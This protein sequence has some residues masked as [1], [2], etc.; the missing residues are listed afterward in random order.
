MCSQ[1]TRRCLFGGALFAAGLVQG[2][3]AAPMMTFGSGYSSGTIEADGAG[4]SYYLSYGGPGPSPFADGSY[5]GGGLDATFDASRT[6]V[7]LTHERNDSAMWSSSRVEIV[8]YF[9]VTEPCLGRM[10]WDFGQWEGPNQAQLLNFDTLTTLIQSFGDGVGNRT[11][12][13]EPGVQYGVFLVSQGSAPG[14]SATVS[15]GV[16]PLEGCN[17]ADIDKNGILNL[18]DVIAFA[19][20]FLFGCR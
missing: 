2:V 10:V 11:A 12:A 7:S 16:E 18:D 3:S 1:M 4:G 19:D 13:L 8:A 9:M 20:A 6:A 17:D 15:Y 5:M 14:G